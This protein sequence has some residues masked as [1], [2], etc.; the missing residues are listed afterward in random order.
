MLSGGLELL[1]AL[2]RAAIQMPFG[3]GGHSRGIV[4]VFQVHRSVLWLFIFNSLKKLKIS[5]CD[6]FNN[7]LSFKLSSRRLFLWMETTL[8]QQRNFSS[9][10]F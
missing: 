8:E 9:M 10:D 5:N 3:K 7:M 2:R 6:L 1:G 4:S